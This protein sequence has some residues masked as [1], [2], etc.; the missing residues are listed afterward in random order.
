MKHNILSI[1]EKSDDVISGAS[2][3]RQLGI[4]R[5]AVWKHIQMIQSAGAEIETTTKGYRLLQPPTTP[6][7]WTFGERA[8]RIFYFPELSS[9]MDKAQELARDGCPS[10]SVI[11]TNRQTR[12]RG[13]LQRSWVSETGGLYFT[14]VLRPEIRPQDTPII[15]LA[16]AVDLATVL[17]DRYHINAEL[18]W[19]NDVLVEDKKIAG[20]LSVME[21]ES[22]RVTVV[23]VGIG[24]NVDNQSDAV[25]TPSTSIRQQTG[26]PASRIRLLS[27]FMDVF[28]RRMEKFKPDNIVE[29]WR[30]LSNTIGKNVSIRTYND[31]FEGRAVDI[32][33]NGALVIEDASGVRSSVFY[34][35]CFYD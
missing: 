32:E 13:R 1:L 21:A 6:Y 26:K 17:R 12:G 33:S 20:I 15:N 31:R 3:S 5:V 10:F 23:N 9:T 24:V 27:E 2:I 25:P 14:I 7:S 28:E 35:D 18:K 8:D 30:P 29:Q 4:S 22:D 16:A 34:G 19:P 11:I